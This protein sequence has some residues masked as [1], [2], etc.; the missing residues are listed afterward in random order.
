MVQQS[1]LLCVSDPSYYAS[2]FASHLVVMK[3]LMALRIQ[4]SYRDFYMFVGN[5]VDKS[6]LSY[7]SISTKQS[8]HLILKL[9]MK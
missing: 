2:I 8:E 9:Y 4:F 3:L 7:K 6:V 5:H 1:Q